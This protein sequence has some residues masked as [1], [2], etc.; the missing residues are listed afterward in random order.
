MNMW[1]CFKDL[2]FALYF[3]VPKSIYYRLIFDDQLSDTSNLL[4]NNLFGGNFLNIFSSLPKVT[5]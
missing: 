1:L 4:I 3:R 5:I 2:S